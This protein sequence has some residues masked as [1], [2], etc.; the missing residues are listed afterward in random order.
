MS[1]QRHTLRFERLD[2][3]TLEAWRKIPAAIAGDVMNRQGLMD[4]RIKPLSDIFPMVGHARTA[5]VM[6]G[7]NSA[8]HVMIPLLEP[9][10]ILVVDAKGHENRAVWGGI[11]AEAAKMAG[12]GGVI[13]DGA[14]R[15][16]DEI[17]A[18]GVPHYASAVHPGGPNKGWG[19]T[20]DGVISCGSAAVSPGDLI[21]GDA[22]G[23][24]VVPLSRQAALLED[25]QARMR[26]EDDIIARV[27][28]GETTAAI[29]NAVEAE[30]IS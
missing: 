22:D 9:G 2:E 6:V 11:L 19:G 24:A 21:I 29:F 27:R 13:I 14:V 1:L 26:Y 15:D 3:Q 7:D 28:A 16:L 8:L 30:I 10:D 5:D 4:A 20:L 17:R 18:L 23:V 12:V 25:A